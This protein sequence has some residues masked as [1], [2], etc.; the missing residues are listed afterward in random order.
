MKC[1]TFL[2]WKIRKNISIRRL[3]KILIRV[4][5]VKMFYLFICDLRFY[6]C[7]RNLSVR[8]INLCTI[9]LN[10]KVTLT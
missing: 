5:S 1:Q 9:N 3:L 10:F 2:L 4:L 7:T 6:T 8:L